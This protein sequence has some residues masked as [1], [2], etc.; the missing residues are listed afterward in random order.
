M[1]EP[2]DFPKTLGFDEEGEP[3][4]EK[5]DQPS[6]PPHPELQGDI[7]QA[8]LSEG[9]KTKVVGE[10]PADQVDAVLLGLADER[11]DWNELVLKPKPEKVPPPDFVDPNNP[12][13]TTFGSSPADLERM[14]RDVEKSKQ[15]PFKDIVG[16]KDETPEEHTPLT[17]KK[18]GK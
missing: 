16:E 14:M 2:K 7:P 18:H 4:F 8:P 10:E 13:D 3:I 6:L 11:L 15:K 12:D 17:N 9:E 1:P 5:K